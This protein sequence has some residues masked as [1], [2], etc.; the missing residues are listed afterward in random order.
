[1][2]VS[3]VAHAF[4]IVLKKVGSSPGCP[5]FSST[6]FQVSEFVFSYAIQLESIFKQG[7]RLESSFF[8]LN[9]LSCFPNSE[10]AA[11]SFIVWHLYE[12]PGLVQEG[13]PGG[14]VLALQA[15]IPEFRSPPLTWKVR[16][17][18][19]P[20]I[21]VTCRWL[22]GISDL[23]RQPAY[24]KRWVPDSMRHSLSKIK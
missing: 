23:A 3:F 8:P 12:K 18:H 5:P 7:I 4:S 9:A 15:W 22:Q 13:G 21:P 14:N 17:W 11:F 1:M 10:M 2:C 24:L 19:V 20:V 16:L 6:E